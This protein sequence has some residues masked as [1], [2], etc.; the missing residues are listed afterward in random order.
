[1]PKIK[2]KCDHVIGLGEIPSPDQWMMISDVEYDAFQ[3]PMDPEV[4]YSKMNIVVKCKVCQRLHVFWDG[5]DKPQ[6]IYQKET[7][8]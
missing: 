8:Q 3:N 6:V 1:M 4:L 2:C 7:E 5:F